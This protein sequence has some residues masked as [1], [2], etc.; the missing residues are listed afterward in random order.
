MQYFRCKCGKSEGW[1]SMGVSRCRVC[2]ECKSTL[3]QSPEGHGEPE[4]H[5]LCK[6]VTTTTYRGEIT[7][8]TVVECVNCHDQFPEG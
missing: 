7:T 1:S 8:K 4:P 6:T 2:P 3:A 5:D